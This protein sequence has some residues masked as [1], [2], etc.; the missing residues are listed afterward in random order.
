LTSSAT[1]PTIVRAATSAVRTAGEGAFF[2]AA[3]VGAPPFIDLASN[4]DEEH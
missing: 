2:G 3:G 1:D 4:D